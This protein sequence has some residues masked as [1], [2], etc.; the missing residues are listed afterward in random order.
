MLLRLPAVYGD[1]FSGNLKKLMLV[2]AFLR[3]LAFRAVSALKPTVHVDTVAEE[4]VNINSGHQYDSMTLSDR[5]EGNWL[6][7]FSKRIVDLCFAVSVLA[8]FWWVLV[9]TWLVV[10]VSSPGGS[11]FIQERVGKNGVVFNCVKFRTMASGTKQVASHELTTNSVTKVGAFLRKTKLDELPQIWNIFKNELSLV[12]PRPCL[13]AQ[14]ELVAA[15]NELGV[16]S[17]KGGI[18]GWAQIKGVDMSDPI[19]LAQLDAEYL[20]LRGVI[21][22]LKIIIATATGHGQGDKVRSTSN[23]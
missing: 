10:K 18:T 20:N 11:L 16:L 22:D 17:V 23:K 15:R 12:G 13:P 14:T 5:Q 3:P 4:I 6:Y 1:E 2:P 7:A 19:R 21:M 9:I 8:L